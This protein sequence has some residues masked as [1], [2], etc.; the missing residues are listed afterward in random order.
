LGTE[1]DW[2]VETDRAE[3]VSS[4]VTGR[5]RRVDALRG[6]AWHTRFSEER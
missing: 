5:R 6:A 3:V 1:V 4:E 2:P